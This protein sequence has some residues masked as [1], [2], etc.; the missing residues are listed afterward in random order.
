M[1]PDI[2][3]TTDR[4]FCQFGPFFPFYPKNNQKNL[5][6][7]KMKKMPGDIIMLQKCN[8]NHDHMLYCSWDMVHD[9][10]NFHFS[11]WAICCL[12]IHL[13]TQKSKNLKKWLI[14]LEIS[15]IYKS[16]P[17]I[18][19]TWYTVPD[20]WSA[21]DNRKIDRQKKWHMEVGAQPKNDYLEKVLSCKLG[22]LSSFY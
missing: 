4:I 19:I 22:H 8:K 21:T 9:G 11:F 15:S 7:Q 16:V 18:M 1:V 14:C 10:C 3:S 20:I 5:N 2:W 13:T 6:F 17:K 12:F